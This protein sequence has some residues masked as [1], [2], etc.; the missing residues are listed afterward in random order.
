MVRGIEKTLASVA[1]DDQAFFTQSLQNNKNNNGRNAQI[2]SSGSI[3]I[4]P[5]GLSSF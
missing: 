1:S 2:L 3:I 4:M 5:Y